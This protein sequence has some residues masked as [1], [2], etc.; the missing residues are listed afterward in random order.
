[1]VLNILFL[2][3]MISIGDWLCCIIWSST[4]FWSHFS[5]YIVLNLICR[6]PSPKWC[7]LLWV[8]S[9]FP[10]QKISKFHL[11]ILSSSL[12]LDSLL[13]STWK[14]LYTVQ[15]ACIY[16]E[17][18]LLFILIFFISCCHYWPLAFFSEEKIIRK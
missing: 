8:F 16:L 12:A 14:G 18:F 5:M 2:F 10:I 17:L 15:L 1:M 3:S 9:F 4:Y 13:V 6:I 7:H 11:Q